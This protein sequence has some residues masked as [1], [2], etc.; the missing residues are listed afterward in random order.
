M[1]RS[2]PGRWPVPLLLLLLTGCASS[3]LQLLQE[4]PPYLSELRSEYFTANPDSPFRNNVTGATVV[5]GMGRFDVLAAWGHPS[6]RV[7]DG[8]GFE[9]WT[10]YDVD[11]DS[12]DALE[13]NLVFRDGVVDRWSSRTHKHTGLAYRGHDDDWVPPPVKLPTSEPPGGKKVPNS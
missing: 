13:Y 2:L 6:R 9:E 7:R 5:P 10:Y 11:S 8:V 4:P 12:G 1:C 3:S